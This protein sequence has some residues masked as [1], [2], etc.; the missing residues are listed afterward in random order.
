ML[1]KILRFLFDDTQTTYSFFRLYTQ[2]TNWS[3]QGRLPYEYELPK[4]ISFEDSFWKR[5]ISIHNL[6]KGDDHERAFSVFWADGELVLTGDIRG[7]TSSVTTNSVVS[8]KYIQS[9]HKGYATKQIFVDSDLYSQKDVYYKNIPSKVEVKYLFNVHTHPAHIIDGKEFYGFFSLTDINSLIY[10][11]AIVTG[12]IGDRFWLLFKTTKTP[13]VLNNYQENEINIDSLVD[14]LHLGV[15][16]GT[17]GGKLSIHL[18]KLS[19]NDRS[20]NS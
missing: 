2:L 4:V 8:V 6:T 11:N 16:S 14:K 3:N 10:S 17:L 13:K 9:R 5:V 15:Y 7:T 1:D 19:D 20:V 18:S 12:M